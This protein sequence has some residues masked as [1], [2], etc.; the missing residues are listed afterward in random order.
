MRGPRWLTVRRDY[1]RNR[2]VARI[3]WWGLILAPVWVQ[4]LR[5]IVLGRNQERN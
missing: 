5:M 2:L 3:R 4:D 1:A